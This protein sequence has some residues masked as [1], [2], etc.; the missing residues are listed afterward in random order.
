MHRTLVH[1][2]R[3]HVSVVPHF[4]YLP[5]K[6]IR[7]CIGCSSLCI[8]LSHTCIACGLFL[9]V[10]FAIYI[11]CLVYIICIGL[12]LVVVRRSS[13]NPTLSHGS[14]H[15]GLAKVATAAAAAAKDGGRGWNAMDLRAAKVR[16]FRFYC[17]NENC[18]ASQ[19]FRHLLRQPALI[20]RHYSGLGNIWVLLW[21]GKLCQPEIPALL[22]RQSA[23]FR[24]WEHIG[25]T[26]EMN[27]CASQKYRHNC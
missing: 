5:Y 10:S 6:R 14:Q 15:R 20:D 22:L 26:M 19:K 3:V 25:F 17:G 18:C 9:I 23:L 11:I 21:K 4:L 12:C 8:H 16:R 7:T 24:I 1:I 27:G 2:I 13:A